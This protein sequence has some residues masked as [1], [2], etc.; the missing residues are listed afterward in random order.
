[1]E[2]KNLETKFVCIPFRKVNK[3]GKKP[4]KKPHTKAL[5]D[6][7][8]T[9]SYKTV[10][11]DG[12]FRPGV[13]NWDRLLKNPLNG[14]AVMPGKHLCIDVDT[15]NAKDPKG[16]KQEI[17]ERYNTVRETVEEYIYIE[18]T[19]SGGLHFWFLPAER[20]SVPRHIKNVDT[21]YR[22]NPKDHLLEFFVN[23]DNPVI[24]Y[25]SFGGSY[26]IKKGDLSNLK[27]CPRDVLEHFVKTISRLDDIEEPAAES[28]EV[29]PEVV[30]AV[31]NLL[32]LRYPV[33]PS[34][35]KDGNIYFTRE[36]GNGNAA[37]LFPSGDLYVWSSKLTPFEAQNRYNPKDVAV[38]LK[39]A[40]LG[41][42]C[43]SVP[44]SPTSMDHGGWAKAMLAD[45]LNIN[46][47]YQEKDC[48]V[49]KRWYI[50]NQKIWVQVPE[51][52]IKKLV[53]K[54]VDKWNSS[55]SDPDA[56]IKKTDRNLNGILSLLK[57]YCAR[58]MTFNKYNGVPFK[59]GV[60][61]LE[62]GTFKPHN[63]DFKFTFTCGYS[64]P[65][66]KEE[67][68]I[69]GT[70]FAKTLHDI[71]VGRD[72]K[73][74]SELLDTVLTFIG[75]CGT[76]HTREEQSLLFYGVGANGKSL[77]AS[78]IDYL[79]GG[80][81]VN[82]S[83]QD[84]FTN[85]FLAA[86]LEG[87]RVCI[88]TESEPKK[89][90]GEA[91]FK[92]L[93][94]GDKVTINRK[95]IQQ[96]EMKPMAKFIWALNDL[97]RGISSI[98]AFFRRIFIIPFYRVFKESEQDQKLIHKIIK[99]APKI[100]RYCLEYYYAKSTDGKTAFVEPKASEREK[101]KYK[102]LLSSVEAFL[103]D[104]QE[105]GD[106]CYFDKTIAYQYYQVYCKK[107]GRKSKQMDGFVADLHRAGGDLLKMCPEAG[108]K[109]KLN[110]KDCYR[111]YYTESK[112]ETE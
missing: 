46:I 7:F 101:E 68:E 77:L 65:E 58:T 62:T 51:S 60:Y 22:S 18:E 45:N 11:E 98:K 48:R 57:V 72:G 108:L 89:G 37:T 40:G 30:Q 55:I 109:V 2:L 95:G 94:S 21:E 112:E 12:L 43:Q 64:W 49:M 93:V 53:D 24:I 23:N 110:I 75:Y 20:F 14:I 16:Y 69:E 79:Y 96:Y 97:P 41:K 47:V 27:E 4:E 29:R 107:S 54:Y 15:K 32:T 90:F 74:D 91:K 83:I 8:G 1:M 10:V 71:L 52:S 26:K 81:C 106:G 76:S 82:L 34:D 92:A 85:E 80:F 13:I 39:C 35:N 66:N 70:V 5:S 28:E 50:Y 63:K 56:V 111:T 17:R 105:E 59:N 100:A 87:K 84:L 61:C 33:V 9:Y 44:A 31:K 104:A 42:I 19:A 78:V 102:R 25:P 73:L 88:D 38:L 36:G 3:E 67:V 86:N 6:A 103:I 99:E